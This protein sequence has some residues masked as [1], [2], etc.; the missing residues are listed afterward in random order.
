MIAVCSEVKE[1]MK[2]QKQEKAATKAAETKKAGGKA[3]KVQ[4]YTKGAPKNFKR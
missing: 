3:P 1:R 2:K 4:S